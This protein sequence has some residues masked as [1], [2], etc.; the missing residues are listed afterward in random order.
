M[1]VSLFLETG[2]ILVL[3]LSVLKKLSKITKNDHFSNSDFNLEKTKVF[4]K[5]L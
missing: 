5:S 1:P 3:Y 2:I 4:L